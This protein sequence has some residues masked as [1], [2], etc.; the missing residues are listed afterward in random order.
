MRGRRSF[1]ALG[2]SAIA[3]ASLAGR[4]QAVSRPAIIK[5]ELS[6]FDFGARGGDPDRDTAG[7]NAALRAGA[8][9]GRPV[10]LEGTLLL[11]PGPLP[12]SGF[13]GDQRQPVHVAV[14]VRSGMKLYS[15]GGGVIIPYRPQ[16]P[17]QPPQSRIEAS[18]V[19]LAIFGSADG[20]ARGALRDI[21]FEGFAI[22][23]NEV[24]GGWSPYRAGSKRAVPVYAFGL[25][26]VEGLRRK[27]LTLSF[28][29]DA[30]AVQR[31]HQ[32]RGGWG[33][34][35]DDM[36]DEGH[37][38][39]G[40]TQASYLGWIWGRTLRAA[41]YDGVGECEDNDGP[42]WNLRY[43][44]LSFRNCGECIDTA[45]GKDWIID[46]VRCDNVERILSIYNKRLS[47]KSLDGYIRA[48]SSPASRDGMANDENDVQIIDGLTVRRLTA[49][50]AGVGGACV[51]IGTERT[52]RT[53]KLP[54]VRNV[55]FENAV[56]RRSGPFMV[57]EGENI[58]LRNLTLDQ[59][60]CRPGEGALTLKRQTRSM[61]AK[62]GPAK[63]VDTAHYS[64][65]TGIIKDCRITNASGTGIW[66]D[67]P[68]RIL[69]DNVTV[70]G[71]NK[72]RSP[73]GAAGLYLAGDLRDSKSLEVAGALR[74]Q[75]G[76]AGAANVFSEPNAPSQG[77]SL[78]A[79]LKRRLTK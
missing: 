55:V 41:Q 62:R 12:L 64:K 49:E 79:R 57:H 2:S 51:T 28:T 71:F 39:N 42:I 31:A 18:G 46:N 6:A 9:S 22:H 37:R 76:E 19:R 44:D 58:A 63:G 47:W 36:W 68:T 59:S 15:R 30:A 66:L 48:R 72:A 5:P 7:L 45:G 11:R 4:A 56:I 65:L 32:G 77:E 54:P 40:L 69:F 10:V 21:A 60:I 29:G 3:E 38:Y 75:G 8:E 13:L 53:G 16:I 52:L 78:E 17:G 24:Q 33:H 34:N 23:F 50:R 1:L 74:V 26:G 27:N 25:S 61:V 43:N 20:L 14:P 35:M 67:S 70:D 73:R